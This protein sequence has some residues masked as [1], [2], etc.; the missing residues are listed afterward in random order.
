MHAAR[1]PW[2]AI[3]LLAAMVAPVRGAGLTLHGSVVHSDGSPADRARVD[4]ATAKPRQGRS[5]LCPSCYADCRKSTF[6]DDEGRFRLDDLD[7]ALT[8]RLL[9]TKPGSLALFSDSLDPL[10]SDTPGGRIPL[11]LTAAP[12]D[13]P[14]E[15]LVRGRLVDATGRP[16]A[17]GLVGAGTEWM[18]DGTGRYGSGSTT[19][20]VSDDDGRFELFAPEPIARLSLDV[21]AEGYAGMRSEE[22][23]PGGREHTLVVP[24]GASVSV[25]IVRDGA[26]VPGHRLAVVQ[27]D[28]TA[29]RHFVKDIHAI[30]DAEGVAR[31]EHLP[32]DER[33]CVYSTTD[34]P[35]DL[36]IETTLFRAPGDAKDRDL[37]SFHTVEPRT[38]AG[39]FVIEGGEDI[40]SGTRLFLSRYPAWDSHDLPVA[41]DGSFE[42]HGLPPEAYTLSV[43]IDGYR[44]DESRLAWQ[45]CEE[46]DVGIPLHESRS[47]VSI[48]L[49]EGAPI[50][51][52]ERIGEYSSKWVD[53]KPGADPR[54]NGMTASKTLL[55][56]DDGNTVPAP[57]RVV[58]IVVD[59]EGDSVAGAS[60]RASLPGFG[61]QVGT[62]FVESDAEG[63][64]AIDALPEL[65]LEL[66]ASVTPSRSGTSRYWTRRWL[67]ADTNE[68]TFVVDP[69]LVHHF[70]DL[71]PPP[72][73]EVA[74]RRERRKN[75]VVWICLVAIWAWCCRDIFGKIWLTIASRARS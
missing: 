68:I 34:P 62:Q 18:A 5:T 57:R 65:P 70:P 63:R 40:P 26:A 21:S 15:R 12:T 1:I 51:L 45:F 6:T 59:T 44:I 60:I 10:E 67:P 35:Q 11:F 20:V 58:G 17:G 16:V 13:I 43:S 37:G 47:G 8:F 74:Q 38:L 41:A 23:V 50:R 19:P 75:N 31:F 46:S 36:V 39:K 56:D 53:G 28:R 25:R 71:D 4:I 55:V 66:R 72:D 3:L 69:R 61:P 2:L 22:F 49:V 30:T 54:G 33:Y 9:V 48:P 42:I 64:F 14:P 29:E 32:A 24:S 73:P 7:P 52:R 27:V